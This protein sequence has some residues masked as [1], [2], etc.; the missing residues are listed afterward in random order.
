VKLADLGFPA[1]FQSLA[2]VVS[3]NSQVLGKIFGGG[4][5]AFNATPG[6]YALTFVDTPISAA[7]AATPATPVGY[8]LYSANVQS[9]APTLTFTSSAAS[10]AAGGTV[11]LTWSGSNVSACT[12]SGSSAWTGSE[13]PSG[14]ASVV[15]AAT[16]ALTLTCTGPGGS[17]TQSV[18]ITATTPPGGGSS[19]GGGS[20]NWAVLGAL[21]LLVCAEQSLAHPIRDRRNMAKILSDLRGRTKCRSA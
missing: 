6:T 15:I 2:V 19:G 13:K 18:N 3:Q 1:A 14:T 4:T 9:S 12:A 8:G 5:F 16:S 11:N 7:P 17:A 10:V 21:L 20:L